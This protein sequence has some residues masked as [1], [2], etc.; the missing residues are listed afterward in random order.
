[1]K[2]FGQP[3]SYSD[4][5]ERVFYTSVAAGVV[6]TVILAQ[7]SPAVADILESVSTNAEIGPIKGVKALYVLIPLAV[8]LISRMLRLHDRISDVLRIRHRFDTRCIL[9]PLAEQAGHELT[10]KLRRAISRNRV[11]AMY[12]VFYPYAGFKDPAIDTQLVRTAADNWGWFWVLTESSFLFGTT[13]VILSILGKITHLKIC[14]GI[15]LV[16]MCLLLVEWLAC[17][18]S[19]RRQVAAIVAD[20]SRRAD[21]RAYF[22]SI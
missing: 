13:A 12:A 21:I 14:L 22:A 20:S 8:G 6:C 1:M 3:E 7:A 5:L 10:A 9:F 15:L 11:D 2:I 4:I 19:A 16:Q 17:R 18:R